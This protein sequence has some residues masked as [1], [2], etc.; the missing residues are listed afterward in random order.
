MR[1]GRR[2]GA[3]AGILGPVAF[4]AAWLGAAR[5]QGSYEVRDEHISGLAAKDAED[6]WLMTAGF[7]VLGVSTIAFAWA[8]ERRLEPRP[9]TG[10]AL[11]GVAGIATLAAGAF[12]RDRRSNLPLPG[13]EAPL[14][15]SVE[16]DLHDAASVAIALAGAAGLLTLAPRLAADPALH[17]LG[18]GAAIAAIASGA[19]SA[20]FLRD[21]VRPWNG[22]V[23]RA[24][25]TVP[26][27]FLARL[28]LRILRERP[29]PR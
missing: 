26:L 2:L 1:I 22:V 8:L 3:L 29:A 9:G 28:A 23:Q 17:D 27:A 15:Q 11:L 4:T 20:W 10:P 7:G 13:E 19:G 16:N 25:V 18:R 14:G 24:S 12:R 5:R 21:V 6:A